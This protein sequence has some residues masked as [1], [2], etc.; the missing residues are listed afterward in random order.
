[1]R[2]MLAPDDTIYVAKP[3]TTTGIAKYDRTG[4]LVSEYLVSAMDMRLKPGGG[5]YA[6]R[7]QY[8]RMFSP[9]QNGELKQTKRFSSSSRNPP[10]HLYGMTVGA[11]DTIYVLSADADLYVLDGELRQVATIPIGQAAVNSESR[12]AVDD[13]GRFYITD[14]D[15]DLVRIFDPGGNMLFGRPDINSPIYV[16]APRDVAMRNGQLI[17]LS[18]ESHNE[19]R[20]YTYEPPR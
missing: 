7:D 19:F 5:F 4:K 10:P 18:E 17:V 6:Q 3:I 14:Y 13:V 8:I 2:S 12:M 9:T 16:K 1:M 15:N 11:D 20:F